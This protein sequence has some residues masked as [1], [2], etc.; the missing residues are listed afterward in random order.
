MKTLD[1]QEALRLL[2]SLED[3]NTETWD[4]VKNA[5]SII[6]SVA[7]YARWEVSGG[8]EKLFDAISEITGAI[9]EMNRYGI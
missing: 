1:V 2:K 3:E 9:M 6:F 7:E 4:F 5:C 8:K